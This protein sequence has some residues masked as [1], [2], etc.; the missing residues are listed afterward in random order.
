MTKGN[1]TD[2][3][4]KGMRLTP[5]PKSGNL[6]PKRPLVDP[7]PTQSPRPMDQ[8]RMAMAEDAKEQKSVASRSLFNPEGTVAS[9]Q[10]MMAA[11]VDYVCEQQIYYTKK[12]EAEKRRLA[13]TDKRILRAKTAILQRR[14]QI[15]AASKERVLA[16]AA[17]RN[18]SKLENKLNLLMVKNNLTEKANIQA[19]KHID[20]LRMEK[21]QQLRATEKLERELRARKTKITALVTE[22]QTMQDK[23]DRTLREIEV[24]KQKILDELDANNAEYQA[25]KQELSINQMGAH[26]SSPSP[27]KSSPAKVAS[28]KLKKKKEGE[29]KEGTEGT[30]STEEEEH[31]I[32]N[33]NKAYWAIAKKKMDIQ[34]QADK[35][36]ELVDDFKYLSEQTGVT[37]VETLI[38]L[39]LNSEEENF[40][41]FDVTNEYNKELETMEVE[42][43]EIRH[44]INEYMKIESKQNE[45]KT[46]IKRE[47]EMQIENAKSQAAKCDTKYN[48][49]LEIIRGIAPSV[50]N[51]FN[52]VGCD[53]EG[54]SSQLLTAGVTDRSIMGYMAVIERR[55][56]E[57]V[58]VHNTTQKHGIISHFEGLVEDPTRPATPTFDAKGKRIAALQ[59]PTL[60][61]H[62]DFDEM[63]DADEE[64]GG[65]EQI[66]PMQ[67]SKLHDMVARD[68]RASRLGGGGRS[69]LSIGFKGKA[70]NASLRGKGSRR[71]LKHL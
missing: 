34:K 25:L 58:Q 60:P 37:S 31:M 17:V 12:I 35:I 16:S 68:T 40:R 48:I 39:L 22:T 38:P 23:K 14:K 11:R 4:F 50:T 63:D 30:L 71:S 57:I 49:D 1:S 51:I 19:K 64:G 59:Q 21:A 18:L 44:K 33:I 26:T 45:G 15:A 69:K 67:I 10:S 47:L 20:N 27:A 61:S 28:D 53:D 52:K 3:L 66:E 46:K 70:S 62:T 55:I 32:S 8:I 42:K 65:D 6:S 7:P 24:M 56:G 9:T 43:G 41:L 13:D 5:E 2:D 29:K 54:L 36:A